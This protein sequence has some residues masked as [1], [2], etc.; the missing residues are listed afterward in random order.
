MIENEGTLT[1]EDI[2]FIIRQNQMNLPQILRRLF[3]LGFGLYLFGTAAWLVYKESSF[4]Y[5][6]NTVMTLMGF[7]FGIWCI[8]NA[9]FHEQLVLQKA[10]KEP[11]YHEK[12]HYLADADGM[13]IE[14]VMNGVEVRTAYP[15][16]KGMW[17]SVRKDTVYVLFELERG[18]RFYM[19]LHD[20]GYTKGDRVELLV[21]LTEQGIREH[22]G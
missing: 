10:L 18:H 21:L 5:W 3:I 12:R 15:Y 19:C 14:T 13:T 9:I 16:S 11:V 20:D 6:T 22:A 17:F 1:R 7:T 4:A 8:V 2:Q